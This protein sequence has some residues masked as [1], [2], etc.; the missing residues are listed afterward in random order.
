MY[1]NRLDTT[2]KRRELSIKKSTMSISALAVV[3][4]LSLF[5]S[6]NFAAAHGN[7]QE[8]PVSHKYY[9][10]IEIVSGDT[11]WDIAED[12]TDGSYSSIVSYI[13]ELKE[14]NG[15]HSNHI[16]ESQYLT[17]AYYKTAF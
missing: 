6:S 15:L 12:Y 14:I 13:E 16:E 4:L 10:S 8:N 1:A 5:I 17:V 3:L 7:I 9:K 2:R 11:L